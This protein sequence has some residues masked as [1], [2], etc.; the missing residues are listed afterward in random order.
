ML[1]DLIVTITRFVDEAVTLS[2]GVTIPKGVRFIVPNP[3]L[4]DEE[5]YKDAKNFD[6]YRFLKLRE[7]PGASSKYQ[8][9]APTFEHN[10]FG[11][12]QHSCPGRFFASNEIKLIM[13]HL[14]LKF[15][16]K[17]KDGVGRPPKLPSHGGSNLA[18]GSFPIMYKSRTPEVDF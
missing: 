8:F 17:F 13:A 16:W 18:D 1:T 4:K 11:L 7:E 10:A 9:A 12:G 15:D 2:N 3:Q 5:Y 14:L 6:G